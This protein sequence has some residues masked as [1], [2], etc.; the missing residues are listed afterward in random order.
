MP[1][2]TQ[3]AINQSQGRTFPLMMRHFLRHD[4]DVILIGE[5]RDVE[6]AKLAIEAANTGHLVFSTLH[7]NDAVSAIKR[8]GNMDGI[9]VGDFS[10]CLKGVLAQRLIKVFNSDI[11]SGVA[12][13]MSE[14]KFKTFVAD[15]RLTKLDIGAAINEICGEDAV[16]TNTYFGFETDEAQ[17]KGRTAITEFWKIGAKSQ[18]YIF[19]NK[20]STRDLEDL[21]I[22]EDNMLPM[23]VTG[24]EKV[25]TYQTS[26]S[27]LV[28]TVGIESLRK[29]KKILVERFFND[30]QNTK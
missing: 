11:R 1:G 17:F 27:E 4:P 6:T 28:K 13:K 3:V 15:N 16:A 24:M 25:L 9:D 2:L 19:G 10:F 7:T 20:F 30:K 5:I 26:F 8:L 12:A 22:N 29:H 18:D 21:A 14:E 23:C